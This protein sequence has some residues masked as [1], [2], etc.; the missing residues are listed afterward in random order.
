MPPH[1]TDTLSR[2][3]KDLRI[4]VTDRC[5]FR[6]PYCMPADALAHDHF[7]QKGDILTFEEIVRAVRLFAGLGVTKLRITGGEPLLR[8]EIE[9]FVER[10]SRIQG[11]EDLAL[12]TNGFLLGEKAHALKAAGLNRVTVSLDAL[13][14][15]TFGK[16]TGQDYPVERV[17]NGIR[18]AEDA[19]LHPVKIN[20]VVQRGVNE[21]AILDLARRFHGT[22]H[23]VRFIEY[24]D[25]GSRNRW[26]PDQVVPAE[27]IIR[28]IHAEMPLQPTD[29]NYTGEVA[30]RYSYS[31]GGGEIG[32][33]ASITHP[34][35]G[36][37]SRA[38][39]STDGKIYTCLFSAHGTDLKT[40]LR[41]GTADDE[42][43]ELIRAV[44]A[45]RT[46]RYSELRAQGTPQ[47]VAAP[48]IEMY[49]IGG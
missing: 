34:F 44:W 9:T 36:D 30:R 1:T 49:K 8:R 38:R 10:L 24:M 35:C 23:I 32:L 45:R 12:T 3:L 17:L 27:E 37:C 31:D 28:R 6:C 25:V 26:Q 41:C 43:R 21:H 40:P 15:P 4:S 13:D 14:D 19:G 46:D 16:M 39:L 18:K 20:T 11:I 29:P 33:I 42:L 7:L 2:P 48:R 47:S 22:G 5:N